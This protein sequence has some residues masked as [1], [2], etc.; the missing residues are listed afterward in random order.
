M[1]SRATISFSMAVLLV[2]LVTFF[3]RELSAADSDRPPSTPNL[4]RPTLFLIGDSTVKNSTRGLQGWGTSL[5]AWFDT[6]R[7]R[8]ENRAL[9][10]RSSRSYLREG[11]WDKVLT[12]L[13]PGDF[14]MMQF[15][16]NDGGPLDE[17]KARASLKGNGDE[18]RDVVIKE[19]GT[20]QTVH[21]YGW[22]LRKYIVDTKAKGAM[23]IVCSLVPRNMWS[24]GKVNRSASDY[25]RWAADA[26]K[27]EGAE[28]ID[29]NEIIA[30]SYETVG[31]EKVQAEYFTAADHTHTTPAGAEI[32]A[33][34]VIQGLR[35]LNDCQLKASILGSPKSHAKR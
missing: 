31:P 2:F 35:G 9:G 13:R 8:V 24:R 15:G 22:Y 10:G 30:A 6:T 26:A 5:G 28:F 17:A 11:L 1:I 19:T 16:H 4:D 34:C 23:P 21:T 25:G 14:V 32:A 3:G 12:E 33:A 29:L 7:I 18:T 27:Q 20:P